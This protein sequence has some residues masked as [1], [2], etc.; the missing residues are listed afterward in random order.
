[1][2]T[3]MPLQDDYQV[4]I[5]SFKGPLDLLLF[6]IRRA[7]VDITDIPIAEV[8]DQYL[9]FLKQIKSIDI[10]LAG[11]F[12]VM[13]ATLVELKS[14]V[15]QS[16][17]ARSDDDSISEIA[18]DL[19]ESDPR[20][21]LVQQLLSYQKYRVAADD[22]IE[23]KEEFAQRF[24]AMPGLREADTTEEETVEPAEVELEDAHVF[25]L[26]EAYER[27]IE[28]VDFSK[29]GDHE[30]EYDDTPIGLHQD[31]LIDR[32][33]TASLKRITLQDAWLGKSKND[34]IG[35]FLATLELVRQRRIL[36]V[37][38]DIHGEIMLQLNEDPDEISTEDPVPDEQSEEGT[39]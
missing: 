15:L 18:L 12:L 26:F 1:M 17:R 29:L 32:M 9:S 4:T 25:D 13:A 35:L 20:Y 24:P 30:V 11:E 31:D 38:D 7:E 14:R 8:T 3:T 6:L 33:M 37:Q 27:I 34:V 19:D 5:S 21:E 2:A 28:S 22:L 16:D 39:N 36:V 10:D 23:R